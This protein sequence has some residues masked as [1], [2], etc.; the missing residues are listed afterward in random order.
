MSRIM[1][2]A[3]NTMNQL[4]KQLDLIGH[5]IANVDTVGYKNRNATFQELLTQQNNNQALNQYETVRNTPLGIRLST[6]AAL[7]QT[8]LNLS[9]GAM[10]T[11]DRML[12]FALT[13]EDQFFTV[14][15]TENGQTSTQ[16]TRNG[17]FYLSSI[18]NNEV[19]L[20]TAEGHPVLDSNE[21]PV[22]LPENIKEIQLQPGGVIT[23]ELTNG[24]ALARELGLA[25]VIRP[26][27]LE[28]RPGSLF[29]L[30]AANI[31]NPQD[32][33]TLMQGGARGDIGMR[34]GVLE[35][36][37]VDLAT[38]LTEMTL[39]QRSYSFNAR[40]VQFADQMMG[41]VNGLKV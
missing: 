10:R 2:N 22:I 37:N 18:N 26:Q 14:Q 15:V 35:Q 33:L 3:T 6:G 34:Q 28:S 31:A 11:T 20:V 24:Q 25:Q 38:E 12:D 13:Q 16:F 9:Q 23:A 5:N 36:S 19:M 8:K 29:A 7:S 32:V 27:M 39:M 1:L 30:P 17:V 40:S 4:Q 41:L 21:A